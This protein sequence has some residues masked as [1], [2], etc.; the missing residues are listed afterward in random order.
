MPMKNAGK[1]ATPG[2]CSMTTTWQRILFG[3]DVAG[4]FLFPRLGSGQASY[5]VSG[6]LVRRH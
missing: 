6:D 4:Y 2:R 5:V 3:G 1:E